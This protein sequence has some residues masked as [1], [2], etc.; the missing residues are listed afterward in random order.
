MNNVKKNKLHWWLVIISFVMSVMM[1]GTFIFG[2]VSKSDDSTTDMLS[3]KDYIIGTIDDSGKILESKKSAYTKDMYD[4][5]D[6]EIT[7]DEETATVTYR[8]VYYD[9]EKKFISV[10]DELEDDYDITSLPVNAKYFRLI[11]TP[12]MVDGEDVTLTL[13]NKAKYV[14]QLE[15]TYK[16]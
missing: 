4:V 3:S 14:E 13:F 11:V 2:V 7:V 1:F 12:Y 10:S 5:T 16:K 8:V 6:L 9:E 15:V